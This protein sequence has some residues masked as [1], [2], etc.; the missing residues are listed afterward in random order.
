MI[1]HYTI[2]IYGGVKVSSTHPSGSASHCSHFTTRLEAT[3]I[4]L[5][6][7]RLDGPQDM[8]STWQWRKNLTPDGNLTSHPAHWQSLTELSQLINVYKHFEMCC[9]YSNFYTLSF[10]SNK[11]SK[12]MSVIKVLK[13]ACS[14][15]TTQVIWCV[16]RCTKYTQKIP[17]LAIQCY[18]Q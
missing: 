16:Y 11:T 15:R 9:A 6:D 18:N 3:G 10:I 5:L 2:K 4:Y 12:Y 13:M 17:G 1:K 7:R 14:L 8:V